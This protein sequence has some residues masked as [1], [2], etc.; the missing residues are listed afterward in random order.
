MALT[1]QPIKTGIEPSRIQHWSLLWKLHV[2]MLWIYVD[3]F[4]AKCREFVTGTMVNRQWIQRGETRSWTNWQIA[5]LPSKCCWRRLAPGWL[6]CHFFWGWWL[7][8]H[9]RGRSFDQLTKLKKKPKDPRMKSPNIF[10]GCPFF[11]QQAPKG[12]HSNLP[13]FQD[14]EK[15]QP[16]FLFWRKRTRTETPRQW[17]RFLL[18]RPWCLRPSLWTTG[19]S[20]LRGLVELVEVLGDVSFQPQEW[21]EH[22]QLTNTVFWAGRFKHCLKSIIILTQHSCG[23]LKSGPVWEAM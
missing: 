2:S 20:S 11:L 8:Q 6:S 14:W 4:N 1:S 17:K 16:I 19:S 12:S 13:W 18:V 7:K 15:K 9:R 10:C 21:D 23:S 5:G 22:P 3:L